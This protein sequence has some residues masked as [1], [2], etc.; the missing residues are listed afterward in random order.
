MEIKILLWLTFEKINW[1][2]EKKMLKKKETQMQ[3]KDLIYCNFKK[4]NNMNE[5][6]RK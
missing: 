3:E 5:W 6:P 1:S 4:K 2:D